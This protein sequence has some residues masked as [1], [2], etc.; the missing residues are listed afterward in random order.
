MA[1]FDD[2]DAQMDAVEDSLARATSV[3]SAFDAQLGDLRG[4]FQETGRYLSD[5]EGGISGGLRRAFDG[6][7]LDGM[8]LRDALGT[9]AKSM[10][11]T[12][13]SAA[14]RPVTDH[15]GGLLARGVNAFVTGNVGQGSVTPFAKGGV[16]SQATG[17]AMQGGTGLMG[18]AGPEAIMPLRRGP[19]GRLG[20][21]AQG[22]PAQIVMNITT[23]DVDGFRRSEAQIAARMGRALSKGRRNS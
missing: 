16:V 15:F 23:P 4:S 18:E 3:A 22:G 20:V 21:A 1:R 19:D 12:A 9:V 5:L 17:F 2:L 14:V 6:L 10:T 11:N 7:A 8:K 13:Y